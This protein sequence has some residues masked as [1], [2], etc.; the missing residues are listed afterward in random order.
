M[1]WLLSTLLLLFGGTFLLFCIFFYLHQQYRERY[2]FFWT[3]G[4][5]FFSL[6]YLFEALA[7]LRDPL[8][9][10]SLGQ[11]AALA[12]SLLLLH[13]TYH[14]IGRPIPRGWNLLV[15]PAALW[16]VM[17]ALAGFSFTV[18]SLPAFFLAGLFSFWTGMLFLYSGAL[19][20]WGRV[21]SGGAFLA[22]G[23]YKLYEPFVRTDPNSSTVCYLVGA[24]LTFTIA[25]GILLVFF[26]KVLQELNRSEK[27]YRE[28]NNQFQTLFDGI[29]DPLMLCDSNLR[30]VWSN[31]AMGRL[32][33]RDSAQ[34]S[35]LPCH[36][37]RMG[38]SEPCDECIPARGFRSGRFE[39]GQVSHRGGRTWNMRVFP[40]QGEGGGVTHVIAQMQDVTEKIRME[41]ETRRSSHL[42]SLGEL[43]AGVAHE[44][45]N[46]INGIINY[47]QILTNRTAQ[48]ERDREIAERI[49]REGNRIAG[50]VRNLLTFAR[51]RREV[52]RTVTVSEILA[53]VLAL[54][55]TQLRRDGIRLKVEVPES[56]PPIHVHPHHLQQVFLNLISNARYAL[57]EKFPA[58]HKEK[59][60]SIRS[61]LLGGEGAEPR[62]RILFEDR[63]CGIPHRHREKVLNPFFSTKPPDKGTGLGLSISLGIVRDHGGD[64]AIESVEGE[65]TRVIIDL[66]ACA[67]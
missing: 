60:L 38:Q 27:R 57:N 58:Y 47:A 16:V 55:E 41:A 25:L 21:L 29:R 46:P 19:Q 62:I 39:E 17:G 67:G 14:W 48:G 64:L 24:I 15:V 1:P 7:L 54:A 37:I 4:W 6:L 45:N 30:I 36:E 49:I 9:F 2:L 66:P 28:L 18:M 35:G 8:L 43:A 5:T 42:A 26:E 52:R 34:L 12:G 22:W 44:I 20:E 50:I 63:G 61:F 31:T 59:E 53:D 51:Q 10:L 11:L 65:F 3:V 33:G 13:G 32:L 56:L 23:I 40:I